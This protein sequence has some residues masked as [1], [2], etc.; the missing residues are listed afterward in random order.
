MGVFLIKNIV[1]SP[2]IKSAKGFTLLEVVLAIAIFS[3]I[4][5]VSYSILL[6]GLSL[7]NKNTVTIEEQRYLRMV[8][9]KID[10]DIRSY[11]GVIGD[12]T[13]SGS[14]LSISS[15]ISYSFDSS[16]GS[17]TRTDSAGSSVIATGISSFTPQIE[18]NSILVELTGSN[19]GQSIQ[20]RIKLRNSIDD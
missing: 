12:I 16:A 11:D 2:K 8:F 19:D 20:S 18:T 15:D 5:V 4:L 6:T 3:V 7:Y 10:K 13:V 17:I 9:M 1:S 14:T